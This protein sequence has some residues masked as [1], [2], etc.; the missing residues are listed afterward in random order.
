MSQP[1][2]KAVTYQK[3]W[4]GNETM[5][6]DCRGRIRVGVVGWV[7]AAMVDGKTIETFEFVR[8]LKK[9]FPDAKKTN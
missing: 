7:Y 1:A 8:D 9:A 6:E 5:R 2:Q 3:V 4:N